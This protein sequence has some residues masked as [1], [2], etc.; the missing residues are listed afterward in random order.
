[1]T[2]KPRDPGLHWYQDHVVVAAI[3]PVPLKPKYQE[4]LALARG[5][6]LDLQPSTVLARSCPTVVQ[7][8]SSVSW[9]GQ[10][11]LHPGRKETYA[12]TDDSFAVPE[13]Q[14]PLIYRPSVYGLHDSTRRVKLWEE[15]VPIPSS[16]HGFPPVEPLVLPIAP[17]LEF[18]LL[19]D[20]EPSKEPRCFSPRDSLSERAPEPSETNL[21]LG[22]SC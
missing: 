15:S 4:P 20:S 8:L 14:Y 12:T 5:D 11:P 10:D 7:T 9:G 18:S 6:H 17:E 1:M 19:E 3:P 16:L 22:T 2:R 13:A 21:H